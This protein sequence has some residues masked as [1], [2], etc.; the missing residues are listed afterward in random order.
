MPKPEV[1]FISG[2]IDTGPRAEYFKTHY[3]AP[4]DAAIA[5]DHRFVIGPIPSGVDADTL[6][7]L[8]AYPV[9]PSRITVFVT[10]TEDQTAGDGFRARGVNVQVVG[11]RTTLP[12]ERDAAMTAASTYD[13]LRIRTEEEAQELYG[14]AYRPGH[15]TNTE[16]NWKRRRGSPTREAPDGWTETSPSRA[17]RKNGWL[18]RL[19]AKL[20]R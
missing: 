19:S 6:D 5:R 9:E 12:R 7:Y 10:G 13:I 18:G 16:F 14:R 20:P 4:I 3:V 2:P 1:A 15:M 8:L 11:D 17:T